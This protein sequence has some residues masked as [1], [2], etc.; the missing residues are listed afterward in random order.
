MGGLER[1][2]STALSSCTERSARHCCRQSRRGFS[3][4]ELLVVLAIIGIL[5]GLT[6]PSYRQHQLRSVVTEARLSLQTMATTQEQMR[7]KHGRYQSLDELLIH[8]A[9]SERINQ[10]YALDLQLPNDGL[11]FRLSM[12]PRLSEETLPTLT[13]DHW[14]QF[15]SDG[16]VL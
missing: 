9:L 8:V 11:A 1:S 13:L 5:A 16:W 14:G 2:L 10:H 6:Y 3:L 15:S 7:L 12:V 4:I